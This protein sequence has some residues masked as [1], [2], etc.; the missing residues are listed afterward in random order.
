LAFGSDEAKKQSY[1]I[2]GKYKIDVEFLIILIAIGELS[3]T[4]IVEYL[5]KKYQFSLEKS[6]EI[7]RELKIKIIQPALIMIKRDSDDLPQEIDFV[8]E[9]KKLLE[10]LR[11][12]LLATIL[13]NDQERNVF[14][15]NLIIHTLYQ[16]Q[17]YKTD[18]LKALYDN[19]ETIGF[20]KIVV[21]KVE[22]TATIGNWVADFAMYSGSEIFST[23][24]ISDYIA[25]S[26]NCQSLD[27][28]QKEHLIKVLK[29]Y[30]NIKF[31]PEVLEGVPQAR[32]EIIPIENEFNATK[33]FQ[34]KSPHLIDNKTKDDELK[35]NFIA[36]NSSFNQPAQKTNLDKLP[37]LKND[38]QNLPIS[39]IDIKPISMVRLE[40]QKFIGQIRDDKNTLFL[41]AKLGNDLISLGDQKD[42]ASLKNWLASYQK[43]IGPT[44]GS[45]SARMSYLNNVNDAKKLSLA[46]KEMLSLVLKSYDEGTVLEFNLA[47]DGSIDISLPKREIK[48]DDLPVADS[49]FLPKQNQV[50]A[51]TKNLSPVNKLP[52]KNISQID[53]SQDNQEISSLNKPTNFD[54]LQHE[55][56]LEAKVD[57]VLAILGKKFSDES[58]AWR[59]R[60]L[61]LT[62]LKDIRNKIQFKEYLEKAIDEGGMGM[63]QASAE[64][65]VDKIEE[66]INPALAKK[67]K[68]EVANKISPALPKKSAM[69]KP[70]KIETSQ[71]LPPDDGIEA[72][73]DLL[74]TLP[75]DKLTANNLVKAENKVTS[76]EIKKSAPLESLKSSQKEIDQH[77]QFLAKQAAFIKPSDNIVIKKPAFDLSRMNKSAKITDVVLKTKPTGPIEELR[78]L[79]LENFERL[80]N[81]AEDRINKISNRIAL[82]EK[83]SILKKAEGIQAWKQSEIYRLYQEIG[84][85][86]LFLGR[87]V[88]EVLLDRQKAKKPC[89]S[90]EEFDAIGRLN[91]SL[92][93]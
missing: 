79:G 76:P 89:L 47:S 18:L 53:F 2:A 57:K 8:A 43:F 26:P 16:N 35:A 48:I 7:E 73:E 23:L 9:S 52:V 29:F 6:Q 30:R 34:A 45:L 24:V 37:A 49:Y 50:Q 59:F 90:Q 81:S 4:G 55:T 92:R 10:D 65:I 28:Q 62:R 1:D 60:K 85:E 75:E 41:Q 66:F 72:L 91:Q 32:W 20:E 93:F 27:H 70:V 42:V 54:G 12:Y 33:N 67:D 19:L 25:N 22:K 17:N 82:L 15:N 21:D 84:Q 68:K 5:Q 86:S 83:E 31:F 64:Y 14:I 46:N 71:A 69:T 11:Q 40:P 38:H 63:R 39:K 44:K 80:G 87:K 88:S 77:T 3:Q 56:D 61:V 78:A 74:K 36:D 13:E 51:Q 58:L